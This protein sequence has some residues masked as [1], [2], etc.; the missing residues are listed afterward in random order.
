[1][2][3]PRCR[4]ESPDDTIRCDCGFD[5]ESRSVGVLAPAHPPGKTPWSALPFARKAALFCLLCPLALWATGM[6]KGVLPPPVHVV[7]ELTLIVLQPVGILLGVLALA[8]IRHHGRKGILGKSLWGIC[9]SLLFLAIAIPN[10]I[11]AYQRA[12]AKRSTSPPSS[13]HNRTASVPERP[14]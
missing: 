14:A 2:Q 9:L 13:T 1:M 6:L 10:A 5:F 7:L 8:G 11:A 3:C 4:L 12:R